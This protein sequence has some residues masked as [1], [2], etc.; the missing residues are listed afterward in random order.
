[1]PLDLYSY[2]L[3]QPVCLGKSSLKVPSGVPVKGCQLCKLISSVRLPEA[4]AKHDLKKTGV[5]G[6]HKNI[7]I[8]IFKPLT[9]IYTWCLELKSI[10]VFCLFFYQL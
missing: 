10:L 8:T 2:L 1:M 6:V 7:L 3:L 9:F 5:G 4:K